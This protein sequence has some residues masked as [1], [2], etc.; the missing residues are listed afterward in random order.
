M[1]LNRTAEDLEDCVQNVKD[2]SD[3]AEAIGPGVVRINETGTT[4]LSA[5]PLLCAGAESVAVAKGAPYMDPSEATFSAPEA[6]REPPSPVTSEAP[7]PVTRQAPY[8]APAAVP[9]VSSRSVG[10][11]DADGPRGSLG[12]LDA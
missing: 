10:Y 12:Y 8:G 1:L 11:L 5:L 9:A 3:Q 6:P 4:I 7:S 2:I